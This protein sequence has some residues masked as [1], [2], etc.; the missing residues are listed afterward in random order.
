[1]DKSELNFFDMKLINYFVYQT[2]LPRKNQIRH[3]HWQ[4]I[5]ASLVQ[6]NFKDERDLFTFH[7]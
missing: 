3:W 5:V 6:I 7:L 2:K 4:I 1:M